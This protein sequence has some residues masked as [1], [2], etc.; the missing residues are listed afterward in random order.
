[1]TLCL[2]CCMRSAP[3]MVFQS[4]FLSSLEVKPGLRLPCIP[5]TDTN[6]NVLLDQERGNA[7]PTSHKLSLAARLG[8]FELL[9]CPADPGLHSWASE[10]VGNR[11]VCVFD[12]AFGELTIEL[13]KLRTE[14]IERTGSSPLIPDFSLPVEGKEP[15]RPQW[16]SVVRSYSHHGAKLLLVPLFTLDHA[17]LRPSVIVQQSLRENLSNG[18]WLELLQFE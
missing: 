1:M 9:F 2:L 16:F 18:R 6:R 5:D 15:E 7:F 17:S 12:N 4:V 3:R 13:G 10:A 14:I 11:C 8:S